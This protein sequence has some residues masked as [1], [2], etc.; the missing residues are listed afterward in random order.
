MIKE[1]YCSYE[2]AR[3][4]KEKGLVFAE[5]TKYIPMLNADGTTT[6]IATITHQTAM[7]W[8]REK[9]DIH[10]GVARGCDKYFIDIVKMHP[11]KDLTP[12][13]DD[14]DDYDKAIETALKFALEI[15]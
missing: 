13:D 14:F 5:H 9:H 1:D 15:I 12:K 11:Y 7:K 10:I 8:L 2:I 4:I 6:P 3:L